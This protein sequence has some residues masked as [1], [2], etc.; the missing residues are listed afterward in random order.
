M[1]NISVL[2]CGRI[3][4]MHCANL[5]RSHRFNLVS[6][7]DINREVASQVSASL[8]VPHHATLGDIENNPDINAVVIAS[9]TD[10]HAEFTERF[11]Q[12]GKAVFCEKPLDMD[13]ER[14]K[15]CVDFVNRI[16][17]R[18]QLGFNRRFDPGH[19]QLKNRVDENA[20]GDLHQVIVTSRDPGLPSSEY[21]QASGGLFK[22]M[23]IHDFDMCRFILGE[24]PSEIFAIAEALIDPPLLESLNDHDTTMVIMKTPS[25]KM[26]HINNSRSATYG[27]DQR[28]E[29]FGSEG[30]LISDN[31]KENEVRYYSK[32]GTDAGSPYLDFFAERYQEAFAKQFESFADAIVNGQDFEATIADGYHALRLAEA[33]NLSLKE[34]RPVRVEEAG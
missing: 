25:G 6:V 24:E 18:V 3:G 26:A 31:R 22:D 16:N 9:S 5:R 4:Q 28:I 20:I 1:L 17:G 33:A 30:M 19:R 21:L 23:T 13:L 11:T 32:T 10:T 29:A 12:A 15:R 27:Y 8:S 2:G 7:Y 34:N 14:A